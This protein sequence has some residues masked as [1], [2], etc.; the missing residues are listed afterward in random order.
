[1]TPQHNSL[2]L[3]EVTPES[4]HQVAEVFAASKQRVSISGWFYGPVP[5]TDRAVTLQSETVQMSNTGL[6]PIS[7]NNVY[8]K[9]QSMKAMQ[10][11]FMQ[12]AAIEL[13]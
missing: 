13:Q 3:F 12:E 5:D 4:Y 9:R 6:S 7:I 10:S 8:L 11:V 2:I 1:M